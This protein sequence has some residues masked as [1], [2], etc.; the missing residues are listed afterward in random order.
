MSEGEIEFIANFGLM[1]HHEVEGV[2]T[3]VCVH[4]DTVIQ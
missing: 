2:S 1:W 4:G 3:S